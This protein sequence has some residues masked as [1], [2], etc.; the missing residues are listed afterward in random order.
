MDVYGAF[1]TRADDVPTC[2]RWSVALCGPEA[3]FVRVRHPVTG[4]VVGDRFAPAQDGC[5]VGERVHTQAQAGGDEAHE[6]RADI[7]SAAGL[8]RERVV[9]VFLCELRTLLGIRGGERDARYAQERSE[10]FLV[11]HQVA[12]GAPV[13]AVGFRLRIGGNFS[14]R[15]REHFFEEGLGMRLMPGEPGACVL[16]LPFRFGVEFKNA[17]ETIH[18][19]GHFLGKARCGLL[20]C[21][22][23]V[24]EAV[25]LGHV[26]FFEPALRGVSLRHESVFVGAGHGFDGVRLGGCIGDAR[27][28]FRG[29]ANRSEFELALALM[30]A[31]DEEKPVGDALCV[32]RD[33]H[34]GLQ[35]RAHVTLLEPRVLCA[36]H[37]ESD[38]HVVFDDPRRAVVHLAERSVG[39]EPSEEGA[40]RSERVVGLACDGPLSGVIERYVVPALKFT[41]PRIGETLAVTQEQALRGRVR[42]GLGDDDARLRVRGHRGFELLSAFAAAHLLNVVDDSSDGGSGFETKARR[43]ARAFEFSLHAVRA[44]AA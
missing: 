17:N 14:S 23:Q 19:V 42:R 32:R 44:A 12:Q 10:A 28:G 9:V 40:N 6:E 31:A 8:E 36:L 18:Q 21:L 24:F 13:V 38:T 35:A 33:K 37:F 15:V 1:P 39:N 43:A 34:G 30:G 26:F 20:E 3:P 11:V 25:G 7:G 27:Q 29:V 4:V 16:A 41:Q 5:E 22:S 2:V